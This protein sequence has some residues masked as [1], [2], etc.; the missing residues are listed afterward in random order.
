M[1]KGTFAGLNKK[2]KSRKGWQEWHYKYALA[3]FSDQLDRVVHSASKRHY[4]ISLL[5][6]WEK[7]FRADCALKRPEEYVSPPGNLVEN[8]INFVTEYV[9]CAIIDGTSDQNYGKIE[10]FLSM[11][12]AQNIGQ[13]FEL[14]FV[15][16]FPID[17]YAYVDSLKDIDI[18]DV[19]FITEFESMDVY[20]PKL[21]KWTKVAAKHFI[22]EMK[23][24]VLFDFPH[25]VFIVDPDPAG[26]VP[27]EIGIEVDE[28]AR[29]L[30]KLQCMPPAF[31]QRFKGGRKKL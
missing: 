14:R 6:N 3:F 26:K 28:Y 4:V 24:D 29:D 10:H 31:I 7:R 12:S 5:K 11:Q 1:I 9:A 23:K 8:Q 2:P 30:K 13:R 22:D 16:G 17:A 25:A 15:G 20:R 19:F 18:A 27:L 21:E